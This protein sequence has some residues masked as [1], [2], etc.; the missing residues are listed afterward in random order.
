MHTSPIEDLLPASLER[1]AREPVGYRMISNWIAP[2]DFEEPLDVGLIGVPF[3]RGAGFWKGTHEA[4]AAVREAFASFATRSFDFDTDISDL[5]VRD[6][7]DV[8]LHMTDV[9]RSHATIERALVDIYDRN[10]NF[11]PIIIGGDH[12]IAAP[13]ARA[14]KRAHDLRLGLVDFDAHNDLRSPAS[15]GPSSGTPFRQL[16]DGGYIDGK[17]AVQLGLHGFLSSPVL[18]RYADE[19]GLRMISAR[20]VRARGMD[21]VIE[22]AIEQASKTTDGI[23]VSLDID[24]MDPSYAPGTGAPTSG[25]L[26]PRQLVDALYRLGQCEQVRALDLVEIDPLKDLK[27]ATPKMAAIIIMSFLAGVHARLSRHTARL[28]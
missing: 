27:E 24:V 9:Q 12:A 28:G 5:K 23:Y 15:E 4:P 3:N 18:K 19:R 20:E 25:G 17:N 6:I 22:A 1:H 14:F 7:G 26:D 8:R 13:S 21:V 16:I 2:W 11:I 10:A